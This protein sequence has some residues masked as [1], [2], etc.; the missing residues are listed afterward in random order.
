MLCRD[1]PCLELTAVPPDSL[2]ITANQGPGNTRR[3]QKGLP[4]GLCHAGRHHTQLPR[5]R[6]AKT[7]V[8]L[9]VAPSV[10]LHPVPMLYDNKCHTMLRVSK[11]AFPLN[12]EYVAHRS[13]TAAD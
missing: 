5:R 11:A 12:K 6:T 3:H 7:S 2:P 4:R 8:L 10:L 9:A 13:G 1:Y